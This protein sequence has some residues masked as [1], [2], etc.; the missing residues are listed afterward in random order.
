MTAQDGTHGTLDSQPGY[1]NS[2]GPITMT[3]NNPSTLI[4]AF[5]HGLDSGGNSF[6][7]PW[8]YCC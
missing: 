5:A 1:W 7:T 4:M 2:S 6:Y 8:E 3:D